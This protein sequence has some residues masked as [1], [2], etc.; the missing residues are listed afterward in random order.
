MTI[1][2]TLGTWMVPLIITLLSIICVA[3]VSYFNSDDWGV[4]DSIIFAAL[5][6]IATITAWVVWLI[7]TLMTK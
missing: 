7:M 5:G 3:L 6:I 1:T 4:F 2:L